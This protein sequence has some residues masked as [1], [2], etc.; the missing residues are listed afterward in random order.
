M[1]DE[2]RA[3]L[4][5]LAQRLPKR[6]RTVLELLLRDGEVSTYKLGQLGYDQPPRAA[7]DLKDHGVRLKTKRAKHPISGAQ[8]VIYY[9]DDDQ[10]IDTSYI[11]RQT[12]SKR[13]RSEVLEHYNHSCALCRSTFSS[14]YLQID[15][16][17]PF[18]LSSDPASLVVKD[19]QLLCAAH[20]RAKSW[21][22]E[23]CANRIARDPSVCG[24]CYWAF[25]D[26]YTH[27]ATKQHRLVELSFTTEPEMSLYHR[28]ARTAQEQGI[29]IASVIKKFL[30]K[31]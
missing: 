27:I 28:L 1:T 22:C 25:P 9:I 23:N 7:Q 20:Q 17:I 11:G 21:E 30:A 29:S 2:L 5:E 13:F 14:R 6:P 24:T 10:G 12:F 3:E 19:F 18:L 16:R 4:T 8:M 26:N 31:L 15:H